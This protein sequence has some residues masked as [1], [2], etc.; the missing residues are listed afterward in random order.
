MDV[1]ARRGRGAGSCRR[2]RRPTA[3]RR[4]PGPLPFRRASPSRPNGRLRARPA[5]GPRPPPSRPAGDLRAGAEDRA[6]VAGLRV[7]DLGRLGHS[8][9]DVAPVDAFPAERPRS[10]PGAR[11]TGSPTGPC[12]RRAA[13]ARGPSR[14]RSPLRASRSWAKANGGAARLVARGEVAQLVE[15]TAE[16]RGVAGSSP[17]LAMIRGRDPDVVARTGLGQGGG[18]AAVDRD[19]PASRR[20]PR[21]GSARR[22]RRPR[23]SRRRRR[24]TG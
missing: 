5:C 3:R 6:E 21:R 24:S 22:G 18:V 13:A 12:R 14:H 19:R 15:H 9:L 23:R 7:A 11:R 17:A 1:P 16:N 4:G 10:A 20:S 8:R 2:A